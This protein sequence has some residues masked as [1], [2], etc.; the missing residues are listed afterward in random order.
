[1]QNMTKEE[2]VNTIDKTLAKKIPKYVRLS[3]GK[4]GSKQLK[5]TTKTPV[6][7]VFL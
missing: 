4:L 3:E 1:M 2:E 6:L 7:I 5:V